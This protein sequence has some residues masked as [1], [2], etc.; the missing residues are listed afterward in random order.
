M[1]S[2]FKM[3]AAEKVLRINQLDALE[4]DSELIAAV[5]DKFFNIFG[6]LP[7]TTLI[8]HYTDRETEIRIK[9]T[10]DISTQLPP[11]S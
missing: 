1:P 8:E 3:A 9:G 11:L 4:L 10:I 6:F 2:S 5:Q 7:S